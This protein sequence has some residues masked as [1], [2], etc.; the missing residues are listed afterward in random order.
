MRRSNALLTVALCG[1]LA[2][3]AVED[4]A[5]PNAIAGK[6]EVATVEAAAAPAPTAV[7]VPD[8]TTPGRN[9]APSP[10]EARQVVVD[11]YA[12]IN[13]RDYRKAYSLW[14]G[15]GAASRQSFENFSGGYANTES[16]E[17]DVG[18]ATGQEG[19][20]GSR[21]IM[22]PVELQARQYNGALHSYRGRFALRAAVA[23]GA[24]EQQ[25]RWHLDS[26]EMQRLTDDAPASG[27]TE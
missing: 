4:K 15:E 21:Y 20:A 3:C 7:A 8:D 10:A 9:I 25:R 11:Y 19:A 26:A 13:A 1:C 23:D 5:G 27:T 22:V 12:A 2:A 16:V 18:E 24:S 17:A 14:S 6:G